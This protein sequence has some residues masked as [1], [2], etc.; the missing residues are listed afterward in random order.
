MN[1]LLMI[2]FFSS[3][4]LYF[5]Q[6]SIWSKPLPIAF[7]TIACLIDYRRTLFEKKKKRT[8]Y[9]LLLFFGL[10][11]SMVGDIFL[12]CSDHDSFPLRLTP[13]DSFNV[14]L[15]AFFIAHLFYIRAFYKKSTSAWEKSSVMKVVGCVVLSYYAIMMR[16]I[17]PIVEHKLIGPVAG[18]GVAISLMMYHAI[19]RFSD[20]PKDSSISQSSKLYGLLG[21]LFFVLSDSVLAINKFY[22]KVDNGQTI[23]MV[24]YYIGQFLIACSSQSATAE[25]VKTIN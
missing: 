16:I 15:V 11:N 7:L 23:I 2:S 21:S 14:G 5:V 25:S 9:S 20:I 24:T 19:Q 10:L 1:L 3:A 13:G 12:W 6:P 8:K 22:T 18:Y 4:A 17:L